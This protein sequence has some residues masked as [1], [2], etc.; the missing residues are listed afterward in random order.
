MY[1]N[2]DSKAQDLSNYATN[3]DY[4]T[5]IVYDMKL[6]MLLFSKFAASM[7]R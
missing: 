6:E 2:T 3:L 1:R 4:H 7:V 5:G